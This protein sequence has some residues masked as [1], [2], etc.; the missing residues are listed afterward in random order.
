MFALKFE[1]QLLSTDHA[2]ELSL[3]LSDMNR[4]Q[5]RY[6]VFSFLSLHIMMK[7]LV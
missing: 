6:V 2:L 5:S 4:L 7:T 1:V 3:G